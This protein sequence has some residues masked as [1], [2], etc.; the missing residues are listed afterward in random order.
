MLLNVPIPRSAC[1]LVLIQLSLCLIFVISPAYEACLVQT[2]HKISSLSYL[3]PPDDSNPIFIARGTDNDIANI[4][5]EI[6]NQA[7]RS[8]NPLTGDLLPKT[9]DIP[10]MKLAQ[11]TKSF[12]NPSGYSTITVVSTLCHL[13]H[14]VASLSIHVETLLAR[15][16]H[17]LHFTGHDDSTFRPVLRP[18]KLCHVLNF[19]LLSLGGQTPHTQRLRPL[20]GGNR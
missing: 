1:S 13:R 9:H 7:A 16:L 14:S 19:L 17:T 15:Q 2:S 18:V 10:D 6:W 11:D 3:R 8:A 20:R 4:V 12:N 5:N